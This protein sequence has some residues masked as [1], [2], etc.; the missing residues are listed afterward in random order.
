[1]ANQLAVADWAVIGCY[2]FGVLAVGIYAMY[3]SRKAGKANVNS[4]FLGGRQMT[5]VTVGASLFGSNIAVSHFIGL[6]GSGAV[7]GIAVGA[8][9]WNAMFVLLCLGYFFV[10]VYLSSNIVTIPDY[11]ARRLGGERL[12]I[13]LTIVTLTMYILTIT[14][15]NLFAGSIFIQEVL[16]VN[17]YVAVCIVLAIVAV[18]T[19]L[20]GLKAVMWTDTVQTFIM[21]IAALIMA[22]ISYREI[23]GVKNI[24][25]LYMN[26][27]PSV[28]PNDT[29]LYN[30][31][32]LNICGLP[33]EDS[34]NMF[35]NAKN[36]DL[37]WPGLVGAFLNSFW[38]WCTD[39]IIV[40]RTLAAKN[41]FHAKVGA[42][43]AALMKLTPVFFMVFVGM[44]A[45]IKL[46]DLVAC[47]TEETCLEQCGIAA[48]CSNYQPFFIRHNMFH[49]SE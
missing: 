29:K 12:Q 28:L 22:V 36:A 8:Y 44:V 26:A 38:Y 48:G 45:R 47:A 1:M 5:W 23:G 7:A 46:T 39:Q 3:T 27:I 15:A 9:E 14:S 24:Q 11:L 2:F 30:D 21:L 41:L 17:I 31:S 43:V 20:G 19:I 37:P 34:F 25:T 4:F 33:R 49:F 16:P 32:S 18:Y 35:R 6:A 10:P 40:Q 42:A 13:Y